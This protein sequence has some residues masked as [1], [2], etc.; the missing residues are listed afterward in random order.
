VR[1]FRL[2]GGAHRSTVPLLR[3]AFAPL[4]RAIGQTVAWIIR[5][6]E[7]LV[8]IARVLPFTRL[9]NLRSSP[10]LPPEKFLDG[11][12]LPCKNLQLDFSL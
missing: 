10:G 11:M 2:A 7:H 3:A 12:I 5:T 8:L 4:P 6:S 1:G 9:F